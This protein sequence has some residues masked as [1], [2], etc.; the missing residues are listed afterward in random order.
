MKQDQTGPI[1]PPDK[2]L[3]EIQEEFVQYPIIPPRICNL[4]ESAER[5]RQMGTF[6]HITDSVEWQ[7]EMRSDWD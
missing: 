5:I 4:R 3:I 1:S 7:R 2:S 6:S